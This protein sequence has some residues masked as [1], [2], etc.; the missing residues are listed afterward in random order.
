ME[1]ILSKTKAFFLSLKHPFW[2]NFS[3]RILGVPPIA[4]LILVPGKNTPP[5]RDAAKT[6]LTPSLIDTISGFQHR[7][8]HLT[9]LAGDISDARD[10]SVEPAL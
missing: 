2:A 6:F 3:L 1:L 5:E 8:M 7:K 10:L 4:E 9:V